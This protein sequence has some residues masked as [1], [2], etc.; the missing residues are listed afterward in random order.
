MLWVAATI[1]KFTTV[2]PV[3]SEQ[4]S[5]NG[6]SRSQTPSSRGVQEPEKGNGVDFS[7]IVTGDGIERIQDVVRNC[8]TLPYPVS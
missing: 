5:S 7:G 1:D 6:L 3:I 8:K 2:V 4:G